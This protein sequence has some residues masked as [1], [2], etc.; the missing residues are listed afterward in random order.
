MKRTAVVFFIVFCVSAAS[1]QMQIKVNDNVNLK[2]GILMQSQGDALQDA[3]TRTYAQN[4]F[5]RRARLLLGGQISPNLTFFVETDSPN[6]GKQTSPGTKNIAPTMFLQD[7][8]VEY[9][10][11]D[12]FA[13]DAGLMLVSPSRNGLQSAASL[14]PIDY[15][16]HTFAN[17]APTQSS[18]GRDTGAQARGYLDNKRFEYRVGIFQGMRD[19]Q[20][21]ELRTTA[22]VQY[23]FFDTETGFFYSGTSL[24]KK[25]ILAVGGGYD[26]QHLYKAYSGD[27]FFDQP[28][29]SGALTAQ[30]D[31][32]HYD[33]STFL[34]SLPDQNDTLF[35]LGYLIGKTKWMP[36]A[37]V[38]HRNFVAATLN[39]ELR[40]TAGLNYF[41]SG[42]NANVKAGY[43]RIDVKNVRAASEVTIQL[44]F[45]YF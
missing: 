24:G 45:F 18:A 10:V 14:L 32:I 43:S 15:G 33:G 26:H 7:A 13:V 2:F 6:V 3:A 27:V 41:I 38:A 39:D 12:A 5:I 8:Y 29:K 21:R 40:Y 1:A 28:L 19:T 25:K 35:E 30:L 37:Q 17:S 42:H 20:N 11:N 4:V 36:F 44:Q 34:K 22:R 16:A 23:N 31:Y 9:K